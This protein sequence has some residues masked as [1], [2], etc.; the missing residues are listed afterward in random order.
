MFFPFCFLLL[1]EK[2]GGGRKR[3]GK[4]RGTRGKNKEFP[5]VAKELAVDS[6][7]DRL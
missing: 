1:Y 6:L 2:G 4:R 3:M 7:N 5:R